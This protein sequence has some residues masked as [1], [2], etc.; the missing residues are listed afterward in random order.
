LQAIDIVRATEIKER[1]DDYQALTMTLWGEAS[2][3]SHDGRLAVGNT[4]KN[5]L[6]KKFRG[7]KSW[8][9]VCLA[10]LQYSCWFNAGGPG[11]YQRV[12]RQAELMMTEHSEQWP[13]SLKQ[14][15]DIAKEL[16]GEV[17]DLTHGATHYY[18][19]GTPVP[20]W[21]KHPA[22]LTLELDG[23]LFFRNVK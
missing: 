6:L 2:G 14:C 16:M 22:V 11:N 18:R 3:S 15:A 20:F 12:L 5:R 1:L 7:A 8:K 19:D 21:T 23:H 10:R 13:K 17:E 9:D 4:I